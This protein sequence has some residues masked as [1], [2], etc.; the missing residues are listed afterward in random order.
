MFQ[1]INTTLEE[2]RIDS[3]KVI[4]MNINNNELFKKRKNFREQCEN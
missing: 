1:D 3:D 2:M 4:K